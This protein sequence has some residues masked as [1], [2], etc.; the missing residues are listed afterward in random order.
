MAASRSSRYQQ[1]S[2]LN[3]SALVRL[4]SPC[5][6]ALPRLRPLPLCQERATRIHS[7]YQR[8]V[9]D[10][11]CGGRRVRLVLTVHKFFCDQPTCPRKIFTERLPTFVRPWAQMTLRLCAALQ[12]IGLASCGEVGARLGAKIG[13]PVSP[14]TVLRQVMALPT[15]PAGSPGAQFG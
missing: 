1:A 6:Y 14:T 2:R 10:L 8:T 15:P 7:R 9:A 5:R 11:P 12:A 3:R 13:M 4:R